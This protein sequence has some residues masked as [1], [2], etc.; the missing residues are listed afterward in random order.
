I[1]LDLTMVPVVVLSP[2]TYIRGQGRRKFLGFVPR[3]KVYDMVGDQCRE[4]AHALPGDIEISRNPNRGSGHDLDSARISARGLSAR[5]HKA[6]APGDE[7]GIGELQDYAVGDASS[8][9]Q[10]LRAVPCNPDGRGAGR[11]SEL[12]Q[13][14][15][16]PDRLPCRELAEGVYRLLQTVRGDWLLPEHAAR[17]VPTPNAQ[18]HSEHTSELQS[19]DHLVCR[20]LL[21][22][23]KRT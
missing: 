3:D 11:P 23:K 22:K 17:A 10:H 5:L 6:P 18:L 1:A 15:L 14:F 2:I 12:D 19:P 16:I 4:P 20:L 7:I 8:E 13:S 21:E 9:F